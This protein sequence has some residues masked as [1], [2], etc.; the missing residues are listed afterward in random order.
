MN[1]KPMTPAVAAYALQIGAT[2]LD[3]VLAGYG[4]YGVPVSLAGGRGS[5]T[6]EEIAASLPP[7]ARW[8]SKGRLVG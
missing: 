7:F 1:S 4:A 6:D 5:R 8:D 3:L 2:P